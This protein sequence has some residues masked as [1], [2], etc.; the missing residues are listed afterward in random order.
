MNPVS[1]PLPPPPQKKGLGSSATVEAGG[2]ARP[3]RTGCK[4]SK[5]ERA[6]C[7]S[8]CSVSPS[9]HLGV[10]HFHLSMLPKSWPL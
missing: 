4:R 6:S 7:L 8:A 3:Q 10:P 1:F 2:G 9:A 5:L